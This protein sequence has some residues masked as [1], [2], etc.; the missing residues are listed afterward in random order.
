M[1]IANP[2]RPQPKEICPILGKIC[3]T[4]NQP[5]FI[6]RFNPC[7]PQNRIHINFDLKGIEIVHLWVPPCDHKKSYISVNLDQKRAW[8]HA[9]LARKIHIFS[10]QG[11]APCNP[12]RGL[13]PLVIRERLGQALGLLA[14]LAFAWPLPCWKSS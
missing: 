3:P 5:D 14:L 13:G 4:F 12:D 1:G 6:H 10:R 9:H 11:G 2:Q 7:N 8:N